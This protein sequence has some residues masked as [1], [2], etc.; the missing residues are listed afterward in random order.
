MAITEKLPP[1]SRES[2]E[3]VC[4]SLLIDGDM[5]SEIY[6]KLFPDDFF[7][8]QCKY[9]YG[10]CVELYE[11]GTS[12][13]QITVA[14]KLA[15]K[16]KLEL[17]G[18]TSY[19]SYLVSITPTSLH[20]ASY[21]DEVK[22]TS[23]RRKLIILGL[24]AQKLGYDEPDLSKTVNEISKEFFAIQSMTKQSLVFT[25][26]E[27]A[28]AQ[29]EYYIDI[30]ETE[31][32]P[33]LGTGF[34]SIDYF[35][36]GLFKGEHWI[37]AA[38]AGSGKTTLGTQIMM[39]MCNPQTKRN[40]L[41]VSLEQK[42]TDIGDRII[43]GNL[44][45]R[46]RE[47]RAKQSNRE[48]F[49]ELILHTGDIA[50]LNL[51]YFGVSQGQRH[52]IT[53][54]DIYAVASSVKMQY[55][56]DVI[57]I[58][59]IQRVYAKGD[60]YERLSTVSSDLTFMG[61]E[62]GVGVISLCQL[63]RA[64]NRR[65]VSS[66]IPLMS[67]LRG[68]LVGDTRV[69]SAWGIP[70]KIKD[71]NGKIMCVDARGKY[72]NSVCEL[73]KSGIKDVYR[74]KTRLGF[75]VKSTLD[76]KYLTAV[77]FKSLSDLKVGDYI[78]I[79]NNTTIQSWRDI[80]PNLCRLLGYLVGDGSLA[81]LRSLNWSEIDPIVVDDFTKIVNDNFPSINIKNKWYKGC[82]TL[83]LTIPNGF[84]KDKNPMINWLRKL[85][86][87][88]TYSHTS[89]VPKCIFTAREKQRA[90]FLKGLF[91][92]DG[93]IKYNKKIKRYD[94]CYDTNSEELC[95]GVRLLLL[96][97]GIVSGKHINNGINRP[98][99]S[100]K[101]RHTMYRL[102]ISSY[103]QIKKYLRKIGFVGEKQTKMA[104]SYNRHPRGSSLMMPP[105]ISNYIFSESRK[106]G[107]SWSKL[108]YR[109]QKNI[110]TKKCKGL[111][112]VK[113]A[114]IADILDDD[115]L[116]GLVGSQLI[117]MPITKIEHIGKEMTYDIS[118]PKYHNF[119][120]NNIVVHNSGN[121]EQDADVI[122]GLTNYSKYEG[123]DIEIGINPDGTSRTELIQKDDNRAELNFMKQRQSDEA[124]P[125][126]YMRF[127]K[128][129]RKYS[130][131]R[132]GW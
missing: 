40:G 85:G 22:K 21:G 98:Q 71:F 128:Y 52:K 103:D 86:I 65:E 121:L 82:H 68:C 33:A 37:I 118:V 48:K 124:S 16:N 119:I 102:T 131:D 89:V 27:W 125:K 45:W 97:F 5:I 57:M 32:S 94:I 20:I 75:E 14:T 66:K 79:A 114:K 76:H 127:D 25:P 116:K 60:E 49:E 43:A 61:Q 107:I 47:V 132:E 26:K 78:A 80:K 93:C 67:D 6:D 4:G 69:L 108:G 56:L 51:H 105:E 7:I 35:S 122:L 84:G 99:D 3:A 13:N 88:G 95:D 24:K 62:L 83:I 72:T 111:E 41:I 31:K 19:L 92:A 17:C 50:E 110:N 91:T 53:A 29:S 8:E 1:Y 9:I 30:N 63:N 90:E 36:G 109:V 126:I 70:K 55:D 113:I 112:K 12:I 117:W 74:V 87:W 64:V 46:L 101:Q 11:E 10:V 44:G 81:P 123:Q 59:Y 77:G 104:S 115:F 2:E 38:S 42:K 120:A 39:N 96:Q 100:V 54:G 34:D 15:H 130:E 18:G 129:H 58:D 73:Y 28:I 23:M 106:K